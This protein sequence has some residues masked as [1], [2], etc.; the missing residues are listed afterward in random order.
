MLRTCKDIIQLCPSR[1]P[2]SLYP[3]RPGWSHGSDWMNLL[4]SDYPQRVRSHIKGITCTIS[5]LSQSVLFSW[6]PASPSLY[7]Q[8]SHLLPFSSAPEVHSEAHISHEKYSA[9]GR[10]TEVEMRETFMGIYDM[11][12]SLT[13]LVNNGINFQLNN[14]ERDTRCSQVILQI[15]LC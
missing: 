8:S 3:E 1:K 12:L 15:K 2:E 9:Q 10:R 6:D 14:V 4:G 5:P 11:W 13:L 7:H